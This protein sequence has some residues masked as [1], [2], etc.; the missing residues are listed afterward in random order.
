M[1]FE[2]SMPLIESAPT[3]HGLVKWRVS[4]RDARATLDTNSAIGHLSRRRCKCW[5]GRNFNHL[6][7][8]LEDTAT[9]VAAGA[10]ALVLEQSMTLLQDDAL[11]RP[12][13]LLARYVD[14]GVQVGGGMTRSAV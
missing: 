1:P 12:C 8:H 13:S 10:L 4:T 2:K 14:G 9:W 5:A 7:S 6:E 11:A 3:P